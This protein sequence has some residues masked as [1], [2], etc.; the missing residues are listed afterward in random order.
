MVCLGPDR[1]HEDGKASLGDHRKDPTAAINRLTCSFME[2]STSL[3]YTKRQ[4][5]WPA[6]GG[7]PR[8]TAYT[9]STSWSPSYLFTAKG[10]HLIQEVPMRKSALL[11]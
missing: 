4:E 2:F 5:Y 10:V 6:S 8:N 9:A 3:R 11:W 7:K 1:L